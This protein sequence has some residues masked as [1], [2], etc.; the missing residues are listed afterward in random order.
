MKRY[1]GE[2]TIHRSH[3]TCFPTCHSL[4]KQKKLLVE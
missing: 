2:M 1:Y 3:V 4:W